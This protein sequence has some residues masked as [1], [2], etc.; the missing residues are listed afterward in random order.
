MKPNKVTFLLALGFAIGMLVMQITHVADVSNKQTSSLDSIDAIYTKM[1]ADLQ[2][3]ID[4]NNE[5]LK[6]QNVNHTVHLGH[7]FKTITTNT[8]VSYLMPDIN[9]VGELPATDFKRLESSAPVKYSKFV[10][11]NDCITPP[12]EE[13]IVE[14]LPEH[15]D[16]YSVSK[17]FLVQDNPYTYKGNYSYN[18]EQKTKASLTIDGVGSF[19]KVS[20]HM[21]GMNYSAN[22]SV[23]SRGVNSDLLSTNSVTF[24]YFYFPVKKYYFRFGLGGNIDILVDQNQFKLPSVIEPTG[25]IGSGYFYQSEDKSIKM[26]FGWSYKYFR[27]FDTINY[28]IGF[29]M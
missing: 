20:N 12:V 6:N 15:Y 29:L 23:M 9:N 18:P 22:I 24:E 26:L 17:S 13:K 21:Y 5:Y 11:Y 25:I 8:K 4:A 14:V 28:N 2:H 3:L 27:K 19:R 10:L 16:F 1:N 7:G